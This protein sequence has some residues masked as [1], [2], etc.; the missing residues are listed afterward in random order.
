MRGKTSLLFVFTIIVSV[1]FFAGESVGDTG[2]NNEFVTIT[3]EQQYD[4]VKPGG[5]SAVAVH[6][7]MKDNWHFYASPVNPPGGLN[8]KFEMLPADNIT[9]AQPVFPPSQTYT[10][11][12]LKESYEVFGGNFTVYLPFSIGAVASENASVGFKIKGA[13]CSE[14]KCMFPDFNTLTAPVNF[15][16]DTAM[17]N[18]KFELPEQTVAIEK[19]LSGSSEQWLKYL[20]LAFL[21][22]LGLNIMPCVWPVLPLIIMRI[23]EQSKK[24]RAVSMAMGIAFCFGILL[25]F[26]SLAATNIIL[27]SFYH[28]SLSWGDHLRNPVIVMAMS[29]LMVVMA[30]FMFGVFTIPIP[31]SIAGKAGTGRGLA[32]SVGMGFLAAVLSTPC[33]FGIL[34]LAFVWAQGQSLPLGTFA[35][36]VIG[37]GMAAPYAILTSMP[38][39]LA[40]LPRAG[41]WMEIFKQAVGF[42]LLLIA[43]KMLKAVPAERQADLLYFSIVLSFAIW[44]WSTWVGFGS[45]LSNKIFIRAVAVLLVAAAGFFFFRPELVDWQVY[46][47]EIIAKA[48]AE[49][50]PVLIEFTADWCTNCEA[51]DKMVFRRK[52]VAKILQKKNVLTIKADTTSMNSPATLAMKN[53]YN[54]PAVP[55]TILILP[56]SSEPIRFHEI[57]FAQKL[58]DALNAG[59][60]D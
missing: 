52:D 41:R 1:L 26:A 49:G 32:G 50:K 25:F 51:V 56:E 37:V 33:S 40:R 31:S 30:L 34:T 6:F 20:L 24:S 48:R 14:T 11:K 21:A 2:I 46:D 18:P 5:K 47:A 45:K 15:S 7:E 54:E 22:G 29:L 19:N 3:L 8:L 13:V 39:L 57:L 10:D 43:V 58:M 42:L 16:S 60:A 55:V 23:V 59:K 9:L 36:M 12:Y 44:M 4:Q 35:I 38:A 27:R 28:S 53:I 17:T